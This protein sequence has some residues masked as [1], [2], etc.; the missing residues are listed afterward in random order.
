MDGYEATK[1][2][3]ASETGKEIPIIALTANAVH[4]E[5]ERCI[6][7]GANGYLTK[8]LNQSDLFD[9]VVRTVG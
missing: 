8:P 6:S 2:I 1:I 3:R 9:M 7:M 4:G 5:M